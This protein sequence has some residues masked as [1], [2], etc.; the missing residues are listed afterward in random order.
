LDGFGQY[1]DAEI[2]ADDL[3]SLVLSFG[4]DHTKPIDKHAIGLAQHERRR[5]LQRRRAGDLGYM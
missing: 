2:T 3:P 4:D 1:V 5:R